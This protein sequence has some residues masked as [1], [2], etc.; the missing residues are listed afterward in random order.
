MTPD[1]KWPTAGT[2]VFFHSV[3]KENFLIFKQDRSRPGRGP[4]SMN[5]E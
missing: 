4:I 1:G 3:G 2:A 5:H